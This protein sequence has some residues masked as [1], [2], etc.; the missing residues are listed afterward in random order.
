MADMVNACCLNPDQEGYVEGE[1]C[2]K[3]E[4]S[5]LCTEDDDCGGTD[6]CEESLC[7]RGIPEGVDI[8]QYRW[9]DWTECSAT[10]GNGVITRTMEITSDRDSEEGIPC[11]FEHGY[12][13]QK[14]CSRGACAEDLCEDM[15]CVRDADDYPCSEPVGTCTDVSHLYGGI[16]IAQC[17][18]VS[19]PE[20][21]A[22]PEGTCMEGECIYTPQEFFVDDENDTTTEESDDPLTYENAFYAMIGVS[23]VLC[24]VAVALYCCDCGKDEEHVKEVQVEMGEK[25]MPEVKVSQN[26]DMLPIHVSTPSNGGNTTDGAFRLGIAESGV[27][28]ND[29]NLT[30][31]DQIEFR[32]MN[33]GV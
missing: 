20:G 31:Y 14:Q 2:C 8:C 21:T 27:P 10:C 28:D 18:Y 24:I 23:S 25:R 11:P 17:Q 19:K 3:L 30:Q 29:T 1:L 26:D 6:V 15:N 33:S 4:A 5:T 9:T 32:E 7:V 22:C 12:V 16:R 13:D